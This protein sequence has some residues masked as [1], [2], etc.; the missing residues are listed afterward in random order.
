MT[1]SSK[2]Y[3]VFLT[4]VFL[5][6]LA[7]FYSI[8][9]ID[10]PIDF[11]F[12]MQGFGFSLEAIFQ[13]FLHS[14]SQIFF[15]F[16]YLIIFPVL[17]FMLSYSIFSKFLNTNWSTLLSFV[18]FSNIYG[19]PLHE[20][21]FFWDQI[22]TINGTMNQ[23]KYSTLSSIIGLICANYILSPQFIYKKNN[24]PLLILIC[25][26]VL[27]NAMDAAAISIVYIASIIF[28]SF[29]YT[30]NLKKELILIFV[31]IST[32]FISLFY[33][34]IP[35]EDI[36][37]AKNAS[38]YIILYFITPL[39]ITFITF[40][41]CEVD[42]YQVVRRFFGLALVMISE[43]IIIISHYSRIFEFSILELQFLSIYNIFHILYYVPSL[44][45]LNNHRKLF[46]SNKISD[47]FSFINL[48]KLFA[49]YFPFLGLL[50]TITYNLLAFSIV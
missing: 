37:D 24:Y 18:F 49:K 16:L 50:I 9:I 3:L 41:F 27:L 46:K 28:R 45:W 22:K 26:L 31:L 47:L 29:S 25:I 17:G 21:I 10:N 4:F 1:N 12:N 39:L 42:L 33:G 5:I 38:N 40:Y 7:W 14:N 48:N 32:W 30:I 35:L 44:F 13:K 2:L 11:P 20:F 23:I 34:V 8:T 6:S 36:N 19:H 15:Y 43:I